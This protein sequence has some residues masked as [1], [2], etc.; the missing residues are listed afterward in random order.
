M[1]QA[2]RGARP[3]LAAVVLAA[4]TAVVVAVAAAGC[5]GEVSGPDEGV[6]GRTPT[7]PRRGQVVEGTGN[8]GNTE[9]T[10]V[11]EGTEGTEEIDP[12][13]SPTVFVNRVGLDDATLGAL[14]SELGWTVADGAY[15]YD[16]VLGAVGVEGGPTA[17]FLPAGL[18]IGGPLP[19]DASAGTTDVFV[20]GRELPYDDLAFLEQFFG[21]PIAPDRYFLDA[22]GYYG[23]EGD[24]PLG[25]VFDVIAANQQTGGGTV[26]ETAGGWIGGSGDDS[27]YFDPESGCSVM[28]GEVSC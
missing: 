17:G 20:N 4:A 3:R 26:Q 18:V 11:T 8:T 1:G 15:W 5:S 7:E 16:P 21:G 19:E 27:Y 13:T 25:N 22:D 23:Y 9:G 14:E 6:V 2:T 24:V 28:S 10:S 12:G